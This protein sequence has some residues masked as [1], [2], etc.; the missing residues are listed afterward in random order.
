MS[1]IVWVVFSLQDPA[2]IGLGRAALV[3]IE[4]AAFG[5]AKL[6]AIAALAWSQDPM[7][8]VGAWVLTAAV[9]AVVLNVAILRPALARARGPVHLPPTAA[10]VRFG[11]VQHLAAVATALPDSLVPLIVIATLGESPSAHYYAAWTVAF[12]L[13]LAA[14]NLANAYT[15]RAARQGQDRAPAELLPLALVI[16][17]ALVIVG[18]VAAA[19]VMSLFGTEYAASVPVLRWM[20]IG[21]IPFALVTIAVARHRVGGRSASALAAGSIATAVTL[22]LDVVLLPSVGIEATGIA[23]LVGWSVAAVALGI[24]TL[25]RNSLHPV[26]EP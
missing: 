14:V 7:A 11:I 9:I 15:S 5:I 16:V 23:W 18:F 3:P 21:L 2:L 17:T 20:A 4:N 25:R 1:G 22:V 8:I 26:T 12:S 6:A 13:R 10:L 24:G 19:P